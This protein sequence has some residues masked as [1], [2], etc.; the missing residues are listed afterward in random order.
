MELIEAFLRGAARD[1][2]YLKIKKCK[3]I[4]LKFKNNLFNSQLANVAAP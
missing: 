3:Q 1:L 4:T 2:F